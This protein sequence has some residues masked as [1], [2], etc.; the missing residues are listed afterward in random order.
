[1][2]KEINHILERLRS[3]VVPGR[4]LELFAVGIEVARTEVA[5]QLE[6]A[7]AGDG[8]YKFL[9]GG[10]GC[11]KTF[12]ARLTQLDAQK[13]NF[14]TSFV[15][16]SDNDLQFHRFDEVY[17]KVM[18]ELSTPWC[19][20]A[21]LGDILDR[22]VAHVEE[23]LISPGADENDPDFDQQVLSELDARLKSATGGKAPE[24]MVRVI[25][26]IFELKQQGNLVDAGALIS[27]LSG[28]ANVAAGAKRLAGVK[29][30]IG[31]QEAMDYLRGILEII[32]AAGH[33]GWV[34]IIDE[35]ETVLRMRRDV[36]GK[37]LNGLRQILDS[38]DRYPGLFWLF[39]G[40]PDFFDTSRGVAGLPP[41]HDRIRFQLSGGY[42]NVRQ[43]QLELKPFDAARL[44]AVALKLRE[45]YPASDRSRMDRVVTSEVVDRLVARVTEGFRGDV[46][47]VPRQ[48]LRQ[49]VNLLDLVDQYPDYDP[50]QAEGLAPLE[51]SEEER[52]LAAGE[53]AFEQE[54]ED[55]QVYE[56][57]EF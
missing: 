5:R 17:R 54:A 48:F 7:S 25:H 45:L 47:V 31:S 19:E 52:R 14:V 37:A 26:K 16:V 6:R 43:P 40:T 27:W 46:G 24:D 8:A 20:R 34:I 28:S 53:P 33:P 57:V 18:Q 1:M 23:S 22:W 4:G 38:S 21:A 50:I 42:A 15:V 41:L 32:K 3:G 29:G 2:S 49:F 55:A 44:R 11:G 12:M 39:T 51:L 56:V 13:R 10:Y 36:R 9:R 30:E 35:V